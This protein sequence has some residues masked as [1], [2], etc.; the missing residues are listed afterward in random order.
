MEYFN[1]I[2]GDGPLIAAAIHSGHMLRDEIKDK[3]YLND[4]ERLKEED[5]FTDEFINFVPTRIIVN[6]S[7]FEFDLNRPEDKGVYL[8]PEDA[9]GLK[10]W[11]E[12]PSDKMVKDSLGL[13]KTFYEQ[14][15]IIF[16][17]YVNRYNKIFVYDVHSY[18]HRRSGPEGTPD[19]PS[20]NPNF[21]IGTG[22]IDA[23]YWRDL[24]DDF[25]NDLQQFDFGFAKPDIRENIK[26]KGGYFSKW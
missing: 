20:K 23:T 16:S 24:I 22:N 26:F 8:T 6:S 9:W 1:V 7:R 13:Y 5:P 12:I 21:N 15:K 2:K 3:F 18:N 10:I 4:S 17:E 11:K 25:I 19:D 14:M